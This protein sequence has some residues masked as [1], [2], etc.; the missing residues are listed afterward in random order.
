MYNAKTLKVHILTTILV[1]LIGISAF[2]VWNYTYS[3]DISLSKN[4]LGPV[5]VS[6][7]P[8]KEN[9][10]SLP[11]NN[12]EIPPSTAQPSK[13][14]DEVKEIPKPTEKTKTQEAVASKP[15]KKTETKV[16]F[17]SQFKDISDPSWKKVGC[18]IASL[19]MIIELYKP[20]SVSVDHLLDE[21]ISSKAYLED[22]GWIHKG[23]IKIAKNYGLNGDTHD[24]SGQSS[25]NA[26]SEL[27]STLKTGPVIASVHYTFDPKNPIPHLVVINRIVDNIV[28][29]ND[30]SEK[31][32][33]GSIST[34]Q[35][36][37]AWKKRYIEIR[38]T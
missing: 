29:Y 16:P 13:E 36:M 1:L 28:Y 35:F 14:I 12:F 3:E 11:E 30:P 6:F 23:L 25:N 9:L 31:T 34:D 26:L 20:G 21:G 17:F 38:P 18:G 2:S 19:A 33:N 15:V 22:Q 5:T 8:V 4:K 27:E 24:L 32:G 37:K 7:S 10:P